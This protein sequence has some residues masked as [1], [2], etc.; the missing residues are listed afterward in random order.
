MSIAGGPDIVENGLVLH[1]DAADQNSYTGSGT[2]WTDLSGNG[3]NGTLTNGPT[4]SSSNRGIIVLDGTNDHILITRSVSLELQ[5]LS[6]SWWIKGSGNQ[7]NYKNTGLGKFY[8]SSWASYDSN[9][10]T[11]GNSNIKCYVYN[12]TTDGKVTISGVLDNTWHN[13]CWT[14]NGTV[15]TAYKDG[16]TVGSANLTGPIVYSSSGNLAI[17]SYNNSLFFNGQHSNTQVY[18]RSLLASEVLQ[19]FNALK[20]RFGL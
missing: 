8:N 19:N 9:T 4:F 1:L 7:G 12:G 6:V 14:Y 17:G 10:D 15:I 13:I 2:L 16:L 20:G 18:N 3:N 11:F 5:N